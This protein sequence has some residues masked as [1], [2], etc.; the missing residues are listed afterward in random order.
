MANIDANFLAQLPLDEMARV[1]FYKRDE[2]TN[3]LICCEVVMN[4]QT[5]SFHEENVGWGL[6]I[7]HL[8]NLPGF[9]S[10]WF[11]AVS[12]PPFAASETVAFSREG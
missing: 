5:W 4:S 7:K 10:D 12:Q 11:S 9:R 3:D 1:T 8:E 2:I 6:L